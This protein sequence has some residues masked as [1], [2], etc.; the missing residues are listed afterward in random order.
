[1]KHNR[2]IY[3]IDDEAD[4][5][6]LVCD[7]L[8]RFGFETRS[9][10]NGNQAAR[11]IRERLPDLCIV[12]LG[13]PDMDGMELV[14]Q[15]CAHQGIGIMILSGRDS[16]PDRVLG[17]ELGADDYITKPFEP[18]E[19]VARANSL[20]RR[21][22]P[23]DT[24]A[25]DTPRQASF[26]GWT[27][28]PATLTLTRQDG[29][30][31]VLSTSEARLLSSLLRAPKQILSREQLLGDHVDPFDRSI[32]VRMSRIRK[33]IEQNPKNPCIIKTIYG[34]GYMLAADVSWS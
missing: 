1:M 8:R 33:K 11:A 21:L 34:A 19:L 13:L 28:N 17:L 22:S 4:I 25:P 32:D 18:R 14:R 24:S 10:T 12:D 26:A 31:E 6:T 30:P 9:F 15:I 7:E 29:E 16:T 23:G 2:L 3:V 20:L 5:C 27:F